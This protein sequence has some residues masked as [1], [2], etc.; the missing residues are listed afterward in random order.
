M[1]SDRIFYFS[2]FRDACAELARN[3]K[4]VLELAGEPVT[5]RAMVMF[6][7]SIPR[8]RQAVGKYDHMHSFCG[9]TMRRA[10]DRLVTDDQRARYGKLV[11]YFHF[12]LPGRDTEGLDMLVAALSGVLLEVEPKGLAVPERGRAARWFGKLLGHGVKP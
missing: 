4:E 8:N 12:Y 10:E 6:A 9:K 3:L 11:D 5:F 7:V 1:G 2:F